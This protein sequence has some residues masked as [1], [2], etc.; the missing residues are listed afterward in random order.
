M[1]WGERFKKL[2]IDVENNFYELNDSP[3]G[4]DL[5]ALELR[6]ENGVWSFRSKNSVG[7]WSLITVAR[8]KISANTDLSATQRGITQTSQ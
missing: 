1:Q 4:D 7:E 5:E 8:G 2:T 6:F 3:L